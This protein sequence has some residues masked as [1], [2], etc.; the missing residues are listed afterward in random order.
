MARQKTRMI[1]AAVLDLDG[2]LIGPD[3]K[4]P[5]HRLRHPGRH[6]FVRAAVLDLDGT[7]IG[8][9]EKVS[10]RV[11][12]AVGR[13]CQLIPVSIATGRE[14]AHAARYALQLGLTAPQICDGGAAILNP[15]TQKTL[16]S[17]PLAPLL[18]REIV[19]S[20]HASGTA[21]IATHPE[22]SLKSISEIR[23]R[24]LIRVSA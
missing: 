21:F 18:A 22:G 1:R 5:A 24:N 8:P 14:A 6:L 7:L 12:E 23:G 19:D 4:E 13:L 16:K 11:A 20:L 15:E 2:T 3:E 10:A 9:D 17:T